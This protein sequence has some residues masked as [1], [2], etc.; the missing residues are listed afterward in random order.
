M[1]PINFRLLNPVFGDLKG[2]LKMDI[3]K[4]P[5]GTIFFCRLHPDEA[6][7]NNER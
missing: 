2:I 1:N 5:G 7:V 6:H 4:P 3:F